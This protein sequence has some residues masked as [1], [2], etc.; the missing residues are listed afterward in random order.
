ME[1]THAKHNDQEASYGA[2]DIHS[3]HG[4]PLFEQDDGGGEHH[5]GEEHVVDRV[6]KQ[7]VK[8]VQWLVQIIDLD[9]DGS[10]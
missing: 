1:H 10:H 7:R 6:D 5:G 2:H 3:W 8:A 4:P 9:D